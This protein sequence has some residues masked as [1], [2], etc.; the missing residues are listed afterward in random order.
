MRARN[1]FV[2]CV[3]LAVALVLALP[4]FAGTNASKLAK[5][6]TIHRDQW[7]V[8]HI[9]GPTDEAVTFGLG[10]AQA[11]DYW[12]QIEE[13]Y[14]RALGRHAEIVGEVKMI[15]FWPEGVTVDILSRSFEVAKRSRDDFPTMSQVEQDICEAYAAGVNYYLDTHPDVKP[16]VLDRLEPWMV[17]AMGRFTMLEWAVQRT[18]ISFTKQS[19][20]A[21]SLREERGSNFWAIGPEKTKDGNAMLFVNPHQP[22]YGP[23]QFWEAHIKSD[24]GWHFSGSTF[25]GA[26]VL[27]MG[28]NEHLGWAHTANQPRVGDLYEVVFDDPKNPLNYRYDGGYRTAEEWTETIRVKTEGGFEDREYTFR[29]THHG[30][31]VEQIDAQTYLA[32]NIAQIFVGDRVGQAVR[33]SKATNFTEWLDAVGERSLVMF[34]IAYADR[35]GNIYYL[36]NGAVPRRDHSLEW[37]RV[38]DGADPRTEWK[39]LHTIEEMPQVLNPDAGWIQNCNE[40]PFMATDDGGP[41]AFTCPEYMVG[42]GRRDNRRAQVSRWRLRQM[43]D[44]T[45][46]E[47]AEATTDTTL[48]WAMY[49]LPK[50]EKQHEQLYE[51]DP[52]LAKAAEPYMEFLKDWDC[53]ISLEDSRGTLCYYWYEEMHGMNPPPDR[54]K[55]VYLDNPDQKFQA[56][57]DAADKI[58][59][60]FGDWKVPYGE[61][62]RMQRHANVSNYLQVPFDDSLPSVPCA[63]IAGTLGSSYNVYYSFSTPDRAKRYGVQG[64]SFMAIYEFGDRIKA[65]SVVQYGN[66]GNPESPHYFDQAQ[67]YS[68]RQ[69]KD[70][71]F[72]WEDVM[73]NAQ[74]SYHPGE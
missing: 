8:P 16:A 37:E 22:F 64:G 32:C 21:E 41:C 61:V 12:W 40:S 34:N 14:L 44:V 50:L 63:G 24:S 55:A 71:W 57:I 29:K 36:Y 60:T 35:E 59:K 43:E 3:A 67:L 25:F 15:Q 42:E 54:L 18:G 20:F 33:M 28:H 6:V 9:E 23:G 27:T 73:A 26:P 4:A 38:M 30:P 5:Q 48:Y 52:K 17:V 56:L 19:Q 39:G 47:W 13:V 31:I 72:Y 74:R 58:A 68:K 7:G 1:Q 11:E 45:F 53:K 70:A 2:P 69:Y 65:K 49:E 62:F 46:E 66:S 51:S 10:Y